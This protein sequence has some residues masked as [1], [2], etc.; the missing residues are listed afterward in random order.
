MGRFDFRT[1]TGQISAIIQTNA[2]TSNDADAQAYFDRV[3][4]AGGTLSATEQNAVNTL[5]VN[6]KSN[7]LWTLLK[8]I[9][10]MVGASAAACAQN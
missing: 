8:A 9:Y 10:P 1:R 5:T 4:A 6:L 2:G 7:G 3:T